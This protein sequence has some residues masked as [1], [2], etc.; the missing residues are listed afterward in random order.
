VE[1]SQNIDTIYIQAKETATNMNIVRD[2]LNPNDWFWHKVESINDYANENRIT[3]NLQRTLFHTN[4][5]KGYVYKKNGKFIERAESLLFKLAG[6]STRTKYIDSKR[7]KALNKIIKYLQSKNIDYG[8]T[9]LHLAFDIE[10]KTNIDN[11]LAVKLTKGSNINEPSN[12]YKNSTLYI[13]SNNPKT[14]AYLYNK[15]KKERLLGKYIHRFEIKLSKLHDMSRIPYK[16]I[17]YIEKQLNSY[18]LFYFED[19]DLCNKFKEQYAENITKKDSPNVPDKLLR[20]I[21]A[22][23]KEI[24]L[25]LSDEI[26]QFIIKTLTKK[27]VEQKPQPISKT[28]QSIKNLPRGRKKKENSPTL[29]IEVYQIVK[30]W[31]YHLQAGTKIYV[32]KLPNKYN[33]I[34]RKHFILKGFPPTDKDPPNINLSTNPILGF[35]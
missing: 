25:K 26:K 28:Y 14:K 17:D 12:Y 7:K 3:D 2:L 29:K 20:D 35:S 6:L 31:K 4:Y 24:E 30:R 18:K 15:S 9:E 33:P 11:F 16:L 8:I 13:E 19:I 22:A 10:H 34:F 5:S 21:R 23:A 32:L 1:T 27:E